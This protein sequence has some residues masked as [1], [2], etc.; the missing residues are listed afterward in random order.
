MPV[1]ALADAQPLMTDSRPSLIFV[2]RF[3]PSLPLFLQGWNELAL[4]ELSLHSVSLSGGNV[5]QDRYVLQRLSGRRVGEGGQMGVE[6]RSV[7]W[8][9]C[10]L[11]RQT[12]K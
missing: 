6:G 1:K 4:F 7:A 3:T 5:S 12:L 10:N 9:T 8:M 11:D 2:S